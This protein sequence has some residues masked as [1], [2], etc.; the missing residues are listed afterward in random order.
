MCS[1]QSNRYSK[2]QHQFRWDKMGPKFRA[3]IRFNIKLS[4]TF[5]LSAS[6]LLFESAVEIASGQNHSI[7]HSQAAHLKLAR[8]FSN[9]FTFPVF[10]SLYRPSEMNKK[11]ARSAFV[12]ILYFFWKLLT[13]HLLRDEVN[14]FIIGD[15]SIGKT[16]LLIRWIVS[17]LKISI[18]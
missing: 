5:L 9:S 16:A 3:S 6:V 4:E 18:C 13:I 1:D 10:V 11:Y 15:I 14:V 2:T 12:E 8:R 17:R 7:C